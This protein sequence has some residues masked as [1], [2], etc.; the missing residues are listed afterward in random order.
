[1]Q[2]ES[3]NPQDN[4]PKRR[5]HPLEVKPTPPPPSPESE[6]EEGRQQGILHIEAVIPRVT[7]ALLVINII[8]FAVGYLLPDLNNEI[9]NFGANDP[10]AVLV[11]GEYHRLFTAMFLHAD[12]VHLFFNMYFIYIIGSTLERM[13]GHA[14]FLVIYVAGGLLGSVT[15]VVL[16]DFNTASVGASGAAFALLA[17]ELVFL[18][19]HRRLFGRRGRSRFIYLALLAAINLALGFASPRI[20]NLGH[21]GGLIGGLALTWFIGPI[22][23]LKR[24][25]DYAN[26]ETVHIQAEDSN[27]LHTNYWAV[28]IYTSLVLGFLI[29]GVVS[30]R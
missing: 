5:P 15:S 23:L 4:R 27:P 29:I 12:P 16:G 1:M 13:F 9:L 24:H 30:A 7:Q 18:Y 8:I 28:S 22:Y 26:S 3:P 20:D 6:S 14:R 10:Q 2:P 19:R 17:A 21:I 25:P 11:N